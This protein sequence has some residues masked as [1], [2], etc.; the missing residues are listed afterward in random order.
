[1]TPIERLLEKLPGAKQ[2][3]GGW[4]ARCPAHEDRHPSLSV[5]EGDDGRALVRCHAGCPADAVVAALDLSLAD[6][7]PRPDDGPPRTKTTPSGPRPKA[8]PTGK[9]YP[10]AAGAQAA[11]E[12]RH[13]PA[14][15]VW[16]YRDAAGDPVG[17]VARWDRPGG[18]KDIRPVARHAD[19]WRI[20][21]MP[22]L[23]PL[24][25]LPALA[26]VP[27]V[28]VTEGEKA[29]DMAR[30]LGFTATTS[31]GGAQ[32]AHHT[33]WRPLTGKAVLLLPDNDDAGR[34]YAANVTDILTKLSPPA[35]VRVVELPGLPEGGDLVD[36]VEAHGDAAEPDGMRAEIE[37][38]ATTVAPGGTP[39]GDP[40]A[41]VN[42]ADA[43]E[44]FPGHALPEPVRSFVRAAKAIGCDLSY[45]V[46]PLLA[47]LAAAIGTTRRL[48]LKRGWT[49]PAIV[50]GAVVGESG[51]M[52]TPAF[53]LAM[54]A[55]R[56]R[57]R[58]ALDR[59]AE[60][61]RRYEADLACWDKEYAAWKR[62]RDRTVEP[63]A[64]PEPPPC[65]RFI[66]SDTTVEA[67]APILLANPR[68]VLL[69]RDELAGWIGSFDRYAGKGKAGADAANWLG[70]FSADSIIVDRKTGVPRTVYV[71]Q[72]AVCVVGGI[73]PGILHRALGSEHRES[74]LA[75]R[76]LLAYPPRRAKTWTEAE[77]DPR[78][79]TDL[80]RVVD[81]LYDLH[82]AADEDGELRPSLVRLTPDAKAAWTAY[83][84]AHGAEQ[85]DLTGDLA[86][87]WS[88]LEEYA[89][90]LA[91]VLHFVRWATTDP[92]LASAD[93]LDAAS[94]TAGIRLA[95][96]FKREARRV[97][98]ILGESEA[99]GDQRRLVEWIGRRGGSASAR[100]A[101]QGC[102]WL[103]APGA[104]EAALAGLV[105]AGKGSWGPVDTTPRGGRPSRRFLLHKPARAHEAGEPPRRD[106][107]S[108]DVD[109]VDTPP[110]GHDGRLFPDLPTLPD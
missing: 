82:P 53:K 7:Y 54:R 36:W 103:K 60:A 45:V 49:V 64:R 22:A 62:G 40:P 90:R 29:A 5:A 1:M 88:K 80:A 23:R 110:T 61:V 15:Q 51:T 95:T 57:Q 21:A 37:A 65:E 92:T 105:T 77:I 50:W 27:W 33:D 18:K 46:L 14:A 91:L 106:G 69:A 101:Q 68:G 43:F 20:G 12:R 63:P 99:D 26:A 38:L 55:V 67:L 108:V 44:P 19:G 100:E 2:R 84:N 28:V 16:T 35:I 34:Q 24:Y 59:H 4:S 11:L 13:G 47:T 75:A 39:P 93:H 97:Y 70:M 102:R 79:E 94:M 17:Q 104:A 72:A 74:G 107:G 78:A 41:V 85:A 32:A 87:A 48:E 81:R 73:Q 96:W 56:D 8:A 3:A 30:A 6:L 25:N 66:V 42:D 76:L 52:K 58:K 10:T 109:A 31:A 86:A 83:Y 98:A 9:V 71:P 89:A